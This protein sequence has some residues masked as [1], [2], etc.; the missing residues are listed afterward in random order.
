ME[1]VLDEEMTELLGYD[2]LVCAIRS[3]EGGKECIIDILAI[4][5]ITRSEL[6]ALIVICIIISLFFPSESVFAIKSIRLL[7]QLVFCS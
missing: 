3:D 4:S 6:L 7:S 1:L 2:A 5:L